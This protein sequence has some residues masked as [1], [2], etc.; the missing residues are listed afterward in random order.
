[1]LAKE[2]KEIIEDIASRNVDNRNGNTGSRWWCWSRKEDE[3]RNENTRWRGWIPLTWSLDLLNKMKAEKIIGIY[4]YY[5]I[6][7]ATF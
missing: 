6:L 7:V 2:E 1:M 5:T 3:N 4:K